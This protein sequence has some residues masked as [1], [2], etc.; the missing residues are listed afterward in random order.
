MGEVVAIVFLTLLNG[1]FSLA[2][3]AVVSSRRTSL[4]VRAEEGHSSA[5]LVLRLLENP[6]RFL[7]TIQVAITA[8]AIVTGFLGGAA[9]VSQVAVSLTHLN[10]HI[11]DVAVPVAVALVITATTAL[12]I[13][14]GELI[15]KGIAL[16][17][18]E[19]IACA[20]VRPLYFVMWLLSP[21][22]F[23]LSGI[24]GM[25]LGL[26]RV[27]PQRGITVT[28]EEIRMMVRE[29]QKSGQVHETEKNMVENVF[30]LDDRPVD[31]LMTSRSQLHWLDVNA[32]DAT[33]LKLLSGSPH[34][35]YPVCD[36]S[37]ENL[38]GILPVKALL[39]QLAQGRQYDLKSALLTPLLVPESLKSSKLLELFKQKG[40][41][42]AV[43]VDEYGVLQGVATLH[44]ILE[45]I[46]G[47]MPAG[48][49]KDGPIVRRADG[50]Y[51]IDGPL[52]I[53][54]F[55][56]FFKLDPAT[57]EDENLHY[58]T[59]GG[60]LSARL[61]RIP[62]AGDV[63]DFIHGRLEVMDMDGARV[64]KVLFTPSATR[65]D[66]TALKS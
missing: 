20:V 52:P 35:Y 50:T 19:A 34:S 5:T 36:G 60:F 28:E 40:Q 59:L 13:V 49:E 11:A 43:V 3:M 14:V 37:L 64:D 7:S 41:H 42:L 27:H 4:Q 2:E 66:Q 10:A 12:S 45:A 33:I 21:F 6:Q 56:A 17:R 44:N 46:V 63:A 55:A 18:A 54:E 24:S 26:M 53:A 29:G 65:R 1:I 58:T 30:N 23:L 8:I 16:A 38:V 9:V 39:Q 62:A 32:D 22:T 31:Q 47:D 48:E 15:P 51:L 61:Q 57:L 25:L